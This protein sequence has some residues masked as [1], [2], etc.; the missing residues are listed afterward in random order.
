MGERKMTM[1]VER[2]RLTASKMMDK[3]TR[4]KRFWE[5]VLAEA[6]AMLKRFSVLEIVAYIICVM[7]LLA[8][9][10]GLVSALMLGT[11]LGVAVCGFTILVAGLILWRDFNLSQILSMARWYAESDKTLAEMLNEDE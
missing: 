10:V 6:K 8:S 9:M 7:V 3:R 5:Y 1:E 4:R 11:G 2:E